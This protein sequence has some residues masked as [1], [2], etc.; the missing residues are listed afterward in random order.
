MS[1]ALGRSDIE[2]VDCV[3][4]TVGAIREYLV[5]RAVRAGQIAVLV[6]PVVG[7]V[8]LREGEFIERLGQESVD[9]EIAIDFVLDTA[10]VV[11]RLEAGAQRQAVELAATSAL[12]G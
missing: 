2:I 7:E 10:G 12:S 6:A 5:R 9:A 1:H 8:I 4:Q 3:R 11:E